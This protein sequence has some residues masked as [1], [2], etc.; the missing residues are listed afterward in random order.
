MLSEKLSLDSVAWEEAAT[1]QI[2][3]DGAV[4][5]GPMD[6][7]LSGWNQDFLDAIMHPP[8]EAIWPAVQ[9]HWLEKWDA[10]NTPAHARYCPGEI[11]PAVRPT[12]PLW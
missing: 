12:A 5:Q 3:P 9:E 7:T 1:W 10:E 4:I 6:S 11:T 2:H 8:L